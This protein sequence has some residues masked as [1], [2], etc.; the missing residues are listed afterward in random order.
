M[1][2][3]YEGEDFTGTADEIRTLLQNR[4]MWPRLHDIARQLDWPVMMDGRLVVRKL[5]ATSWKHILTAG[6]EKNQQLAQ[7]IDGGWVLLGQSTSEMSVKKFCMLLDLIK[8][9]GDSKQVK[10]SAPKKLEQHY[11]DVMRA[12]A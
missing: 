8:L 1:N 4:T 10:W 11:N 7:G 3:T 5:D 6:L 9:F 2:I 12:A